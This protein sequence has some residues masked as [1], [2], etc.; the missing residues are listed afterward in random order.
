MN[1]LH[2]LPMIITLQLF[3]SANLAHYCRREERCTQDC[4]R[5][6]HPDIA[7]CF[8]LIGDVSLVPYATSIFVGMRPEMHKAAPDLSVASQRGGN[9]ANSATVRSMRTM[10]SRA[11]W[12]GPEVWFTDR[13]CMRLMLQYLKVFAECV[14]DTLADNVSP[15]IHIIEDRPSTCIWH[16]FRGLVAHT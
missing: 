10:K 1:D 9:V 6:L 8:R 2:A 13:M 3:I 16:G 5:N 15:E 14:E 7:P 12:V 11:G 4:P